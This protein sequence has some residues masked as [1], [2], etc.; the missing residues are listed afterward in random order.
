METEAAGSLAALVEAQIS[1]EVS[2]VEYAQLQTTAQVQRVQ[3]SR[4]A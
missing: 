2:V 1:M 4:V 3:T